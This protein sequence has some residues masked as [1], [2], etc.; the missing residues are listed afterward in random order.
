MVRTVRAEEPDLIDDAVAA[1]TAF[2]QDL[3]GGGVPDNTLPSPTWVGDGRVLSIVVFL[4]LPR[5][6]A[7]A[8]VRAVM[9]PLSA[10]DVRDEFWR[11]RWVSSFWVWI[12]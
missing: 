5:W 6:S 11:S 1:E 12:A 9:Q 2:A 7:L 8:V 10:L 4:C 3:L